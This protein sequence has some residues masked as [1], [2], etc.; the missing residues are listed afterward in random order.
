MKIANKGISLMGGIT[1]A[2]MMTLFLPTM[3]QASWSKYNSVSNSSSKSDSSS[4]SKANSSSSS[5]AS[6]S[7]SKA[8][9][10]ATKKCKKYK[11]LAHKYLKKFYK[12]YNY[13]FYKKYIYYTKK[14][15]KCMVSAPV[16]CSRYENMA[17]KYLAAYKRTGYYYYYAYYRY[18][19]YKYKK[20]QATQTKKGS[21]SG[22]IFEDK[23]GNRFLD[24]NETGV[25]GISITLKDSKGNEY[26]TTTDENG[27]YEFKNILAGE[28]T[29]TAQVNTLPNGF[30]FP[31]TVLNPFT[32]AVAANTNTEIENLG[33]VVDEV[34]TDS[35]S[36]TI[37]DIN[38]TAIA[39]ASVT[40]GS[41]TVITDASGHYSFANVTPA[42]R[43][44][45]NVSHPD[46]LANSRIIVVSDTE[47]T[48]DIKLGTPKASL[49]FDSVSGGIVSHDGAS[50]DL[51]ANGYVDSNGTTYT[52]EVTV[53]MSYYPIT[54][55]SGRAAFPGTFEG[56]DG[57]TTFPIQSY[58][59]MNVELT[60]ANGN[61]LNLDGNSTATLTFPRD[62]TISSPSTIPL[63][64]YDEAQGYWVE[65][66]QATRS[67][68]YSSY[69][70]TV[71]HF[72][73]WNLDVK[74][75]RATFKG[76]VEDENGT[77]IQNAKVQFRSANWDSY[78]VPTDENGSISV[79]N[80][81]AQ[82]DLTFSAQK[83][84]GFKL[85]TGSYPTAININE[86]EN[87]VLDTCLVLTEQ[88]DYS[89]ISLV[90][91]TGT[92]V[93]YQGNSVSNANIYVAV[94]RGRTIYSGSIN[95]D[96]T[97]NIQFP[98]QDELVYTIGNNFDGYLYGTNFTLQ[99]N[100]TSY[101]VGTIRGS[102]FN[103]DDLVLP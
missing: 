103:G 82:T 10:N 16:N 9:N 74:G 92:M 36:G 99:P 33:Y 17:K 102:S 67:S 24:E 46:Y 64:Y 45:I 27:S 41:Q 19:Q 79:R 39:G 28:A 56:I 90:T 30:S 6:S 95:S 96:G 85:Y 47:V 52:G 88:G 66:G 73:S 22:N 31:D 14:Y 97:F 53:N 63:W 26:N 84:Q 23:D 71:T 72:T 69:V 4:S 80:I 29:V 37:T 101:D 21:I 48:L 70:G 43:V 62:N 2:L 44:K 59:F 5:K 34:S 81:L 65:D 15:K 58:G 54:T 50:V 40:I 60:D 100:T 11:K 77:K 18:Y 94:Q 98:I 83:L 38:G 7:S 1:L 78:T 32:I 35:V 61:A 68:D 12:K 57:N 3:A 8:S 49:T 75:P 76:C 91:V 51:P 89:N 93:D 42:Q 86:G 25:A 55:Q 87:R 13:K 20:C